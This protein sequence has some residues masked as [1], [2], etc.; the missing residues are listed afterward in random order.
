L[1]FAVSN[2]L[3]TASTNYFAA[4]LSSLAPGVT[5][6]AG[7][8]NITAGNIII[9]DTGTLA[10]L[11]LSPGASGVI[12]DGA[13][14]TFPSSIAAGDVFTVTTGTGTL[15]V[16][17]GDS[18]TE[19]AGGVSTL[20]GAGSY[21]LAAGTQL[22]NVSAGVSFTATTPD[23]LAY[24]SGTGNVTLNLT[25]Y[26]ALNADQI[27]N[28]GAATVIIGGTSTVDGSGNLALT[29]GAA[30]LEVETDAAHP[31]IAPQLI[32]LTQAS[33]NGIKVDD[34]SV[35]SAIGAVPAINNRNMTVSGDGWLRSSISTRPRA[36]LASTSQ[37]LSS[38]ILMARHRFCCKAAPC[39]ISTTRAARS[40]SA[41]A[42]I[43]SAR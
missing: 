23:A 15:V 13:T 40:P 6:T 9:N 1:T 8:V 20:L 32:L 34:G 28:L 19:I 2:T 38:R 3:S 16:P 43:Q 41:I 30:N 21:S 25:G 24:T 17:T 4:G 5:G 29:A 10:P 12:P 14:F 39:S 37:P 26:L 42:A 36:R 18:V 33:G 22:K 7:Q 11:I 31:L 27:S 35:I